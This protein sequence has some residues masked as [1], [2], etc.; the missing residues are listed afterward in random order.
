MMSVSE[1]KVEIVLKN[2]DCY[3]KD[4]EYCKSSKRIAN[5]S[6]N[7]ILSA[8]CEIEK[9]PYKIEGSDSSGC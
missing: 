5:Q 7:P 8:N 2:R 9:C 4:G 3:Y 1:W 6:N